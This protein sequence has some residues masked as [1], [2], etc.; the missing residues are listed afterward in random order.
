MYIVQYK[1][2]FMVLYWK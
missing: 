1:S 2:I